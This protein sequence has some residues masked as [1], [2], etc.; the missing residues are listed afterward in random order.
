MLFEK[1]GKTPRFSLHN[2]FYIRNASFFFLAKGNVNDETRSEEGSRD[3]RR[4]RQIPGKRSRTIC[5]SVL[6]CRA[7]VR[8]PFKY[9]P[10]FLAL[11]SLCFI[12]PKH[13]IF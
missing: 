2:S 12:N 6:I 7:Q 9:F 5:L 11:P 13:L 10:G 1:P 3:S 8:T 4:R